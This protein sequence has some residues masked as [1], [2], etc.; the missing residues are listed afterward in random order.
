MFP[1]LYSRNPPLK[2][3][4]AQ[5]LKPSLFNS[6]RYLWNDNNA[7]MEMEFKRF[8]ERP[9]DALCPQAAIK[10]KILTFQKPF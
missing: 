7:D 5:R 6:L 10:E 9:L 1:Y 8:H 3:C 4:R 2:F